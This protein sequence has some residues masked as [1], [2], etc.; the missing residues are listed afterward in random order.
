MPLFLTYGITS[1]SHS[2]NH[3]PARARGSAIQGEVLVS[4]AHGSDSS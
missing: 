2:E 3:Q 1:S 4:L